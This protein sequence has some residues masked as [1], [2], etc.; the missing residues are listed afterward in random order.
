MNQGFFFLSLDKRL[1]RVYNGQW[2][3]MWQF[4][5]AKKPFKP[6]KKKQGKEIP[7]KVGENYAKD[8]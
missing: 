5:T 1:W 7:C 4:L 2:A 3:D 6:N 8:C